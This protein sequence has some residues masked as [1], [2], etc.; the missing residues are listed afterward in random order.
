MSFSTLILLGGVAIFVLLAGVAALGAGATAAIGTQPPPYGMHRPAA[1]PL[2]GLLGAGAPA[3]TYHRRLVIRVF[4]N[5]AALNTAVREYDANST[6]AI[7]SYG[8]IADWDVSNVT[9]MKK[10]FSSLQNFNA[11]I[12]TWDTSRVTDMREM[13]K[14]HSTPACPSCVPSTSGS[15]S[16]LC[17]CLRLTHTSQAHTSGSGHAHALR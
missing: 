17:S 11:D 5:K 6:T 10:L 2:Q 16:P 9:N 1:S 13:F 12:S 7:A 3:P 14:V 8:P 4:T 15:T